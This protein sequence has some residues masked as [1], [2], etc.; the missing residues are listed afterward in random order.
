MSWLVPNPYGFYQELVV[1]VGRVGSEPHASLVRGETDRL[2]Y[3]GRLKNFFDLT[4]NAT[5]EVGFSA[6]T[7]PN[8]YGFSTNIASLDITYKWKPL[9]FSTYK[10]FT[11]QNEVL[12]SRLKMSDADIIQTYGGYSYAEYQ[13]EKRWFIG[14]RYDFSEFPDIEGHRDQ[15]GTLLLRFQPTEFQILA[16]QYQYTDR[17]YDRNFSQVSL[18]AIFGIGKHGAHAY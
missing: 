12:M 7:G 2:L 15:A 6:L 1:E 3:M 11:W 4:E 17:N 8:K 13:I 16:L 10:S 5:L 18:R 9:Q 14:V